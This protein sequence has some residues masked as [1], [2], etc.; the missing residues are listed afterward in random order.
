MIDEGLYTNIARSL[1]WN[2]T[3]AF[4]GQPIDYP[5]LLYPF[6]LV[7]VYWLNR[8][9]GG[10]VYRYV[11]VFNTLLIT[12]SVFPAYRFAVDFTK[13]KTK[14]LTAALLV[15]LMPDMLFGGY[16]MTECLL[17]PLALWMIYF[18]YR[19]FRDGRWTDSL[20]TAVLAGLMF[21][22]KPG[23]IAVGVAMLTI[24]LIL[25]IRDKRG[26][27]Q[28]LASIGTLLAIVGIVYG[29]Y[30]M[31][32]HAGDSILG[33]YTKQTEEWRSKDLFVAIEATFLMVFL[34]VF[35]C[36]GLYG[37]FPFAHLS[38]Y[39]KSKKRFIVS[40]A[41]GECVAIVGTAFFVVPYKWTGELGKL[42]LHLRYYSMYIPVMYVVSVDRELSA[43]AKKGLAAALIVFLVLSIFPGA[44]AGFVR[45]KTGV[46]DSLTLDAFIQ[47]STLKGAFTGWILT[48]FVAAFMLVFLYVVLKK[49]IKGQKMNSIHTLGTIYL[50]IFILFNSFCA[51]I[52]T[53]V[54]IDPKISADALEVN[55]QI[56]SRDC[57][58][59]TQ[60]YYDDYYS[61]WLDSRLNVPMQQVTIDQ[62]FIEAEETNGV[63]RPFVPVEQ[64]PNVN[65]HETPETDTLVLGM[66]I[67]EH[68]EL[69]A[70]T[71]ATKTGNGYFTVVRIDPKERWVDTMMYGLDDNTL[72]EG[73]E[74][75]IRVFSDDRNVDGNLV[76]NITAHGS[77][78]LKIGERSIELER[79]SR[80]YEV[81][82]PYQT[83]VSVQAVGGTAEIVSYRTESRPAA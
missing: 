21:A 75:Y 13:D 30:R 65:N 71:E 69:S 55:R 19:S 40:L 47:N 51:H 50:L 79:Q 82:V 49:P 9:L 66:T 59:I 26:V 1:A 29:V 48:V 43:K 12:T 36:G 27:L 57:L 2:G 67:A 63:Y 35:A 33:L 53:N 64:K 68:L 74:A 52:A 76:L 77:G 58:G 42:P 38:E 34:F 8:L 24:R 81:I 72:Y 44:R 11:Q 15:A 16:E 73:T 25:S 28:A 80:E 23:A 22:A 62:M 31:F 7:P 5:Y 83:T 45:G 78:G 39:E 14:A 61:Y 4:R 70:F 37:V 60:R 54:Y 32:Y 46:I 17:W 18:C 3:L 56:G 41:I 6:A 10:D 20:L